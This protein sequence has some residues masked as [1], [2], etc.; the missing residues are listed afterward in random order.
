MAVLEK[1]RPMSLS[2]FPES[3]LRDFSSKYR[4]ALRKESS[5]ALL[6]ENSSLSEILGKNEDL[7][8]K[9]SIGSL[10]FHEKYKINHGLSSLP[11]RTRETE[12]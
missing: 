9:Q 8:D 6:K 11:E 2:L 5:Q 1:S 3:W 10:Q 7:G 12:S 4:Q